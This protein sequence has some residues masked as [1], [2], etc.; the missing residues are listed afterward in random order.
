MCGGLQID[1][2]AA[3]TCQ[4][5]AKP[6]DPSTFPVIG[7]RT[8]SPWTREEKLANQIEMRHNQIGY[9]AHKVW[10]RML[11]QLVSMSTYLYRVPE[12][13]VM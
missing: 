5:V 11:K 3:E 9:P 4:S 10:L 12:C 7:T 6:L 8:Q 1:L 2:T 13:H